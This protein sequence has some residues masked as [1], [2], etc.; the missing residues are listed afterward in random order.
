MSSI[1]DLRAAI[2]AEVRAEMARQGRKQRQLA[3]VIDNVQPIVSLKLRGERSFRAEELRA[4]A[5]WLGVPIGQLMPDRKRAN[6]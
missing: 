6:S 2:A 1:D 5:T 3:A 4:I